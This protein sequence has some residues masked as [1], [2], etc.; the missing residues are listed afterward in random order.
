MTTT[1][2]A[3]ENHQNVHEITEDSVDTPIVN[4]T[5]VIVGEFVEDHCAVAELQN[6]EHGTLQEEIKKVD[7]STKDIAHM[8]KEVNGEINGENKQTNNENVTEEDKNQNQ[9]PAESNSQEQNKERRMSKKDP[10]RPRYTLT[11]MQKVLEERNLYKERVGVLEDILEC[12]MPKEPKKQKQS[13]E[14]YVHLLRL[15]FKHG[16]LI[17][18]L[19][20]S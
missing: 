13:E 3:T 5:L 2:S 4:G 12:Y 7:D 17:G 1:E 14:T 11:E 19:T 20:I 6:A 18:R 10:N 16:I 15:L 8:E 9:N